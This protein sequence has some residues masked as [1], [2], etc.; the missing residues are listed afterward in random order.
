MNRQEAVYRRV[1]RREKHSARTGPAVVLA[2]VLVA[3]LVAVI[4]LS[5][6]RHVDPGLSETVTDRLAGPSSG[7]DGRAVT[8]VGAVAVILGLSA[9][10]AAVLPGRLPRR[11]R[12]T[13][14]LALLVDDGVLADAV[15]EAVAARCGIEPRQVSAT[16]GRRRTTVRLTPTS[17]VAV[18]GD[19]ATDAAGAALG[20]VGFSTVPKLHVAR[21]GVLS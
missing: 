11:S 3:L 20:A 13:D 2:M 17:G 16:V 14:R 4:A 10:T 12:N 6:G 8:V 21:R 7:A 5:I 19:A 1:L 9:V 18:D 15:A